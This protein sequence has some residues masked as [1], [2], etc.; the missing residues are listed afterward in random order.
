MPLA[1][2]TAINRPPTSIL[3]SS[4]PCPVSSGAI[5]RAERALH[6]PHRRLPA[7]VEHGGIL[8]ERSRYLCRPPLVVVDE[9]G[10]LPVTPSGGNLFFQLVN[11]DMKEGAMIL[12]PNSRFAELGKIRRYRCHV[13]TTVLLDWDSSLC[14][15]QPN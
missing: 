1:R 10:C 7:K 11:D 9:I 12:T 13:V 4:R 15:D 2:L 6:Q 5:S 3:S 14:C 8:R